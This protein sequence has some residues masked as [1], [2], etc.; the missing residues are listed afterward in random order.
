MKL[1]ILKKEFESEFNLW[2][3]KRMDRTFDTRNKEV[4]EW[5]ERKIDEARIEEL[6][7]VKEY[8]DDHYL[9]A[10]NARIKELSSP[11]PKEKL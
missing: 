3:Q 1:E 6:E 7:L 10:L 9:F 5:I 11:K 8:V 4:W 2:K